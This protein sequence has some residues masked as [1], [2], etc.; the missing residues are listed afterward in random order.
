MPDRGA[1]P[2]GRF[3]FAYGSLMSPASLRAT[4]RDCAIDGCIPARC[5][6]FRRTFGVAFPNDGSESD[7][8]Y[9]DDRG[10]RPPVVLFSDL[11]ADEGDRVNGVCIPVGEP[12]LDLLR[13]RELRYN[14]RDVTDAVCPYP[15]FRLVGTVSAFVGAERFTRP[16]DVRRGVLSAGYAATI[17]DGARHWDR[18]SPGFFADYLSSTDAAAPGRIVR[19]TRV[20]H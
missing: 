19:L 18:T 14:L 11:T 9:L 1:P 10:G 7:K 6:G 16:E 8:A 3:V 13:S 15:G 4:L 5:R 12:D 17:D 2:H 20:D